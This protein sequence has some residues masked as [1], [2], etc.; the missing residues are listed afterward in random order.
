MLLGINAAAEENGSKT[1]DDVK[2]EAVQA[3]I[4][5][6]EDLLW[7]EDISRL[8]FCE[9]VYNTVNGVKE[10]PVAKLAR[11]PF[12]D[13]NNHKI[14][15]LAFSNIVSG[16][17]E[18]VFAPNDKI[19]R[20]EAAVILCRAAKYAGLEMPTAK[21]DMSYSDNSEISEWAVSG[22]YSL[23]VLEIMSDTADKTF[24]PKA[25][26]TVGESVNSLVKLYK[27]IKK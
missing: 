9:L 26:Y 1:W 17:E 14:N 12:D 27:L 6:N 19:T 20:E 21:V 24:S 25:N 7:N 13:V 8:Q 4:I 2:K 5:E 15:T 11:N 16:K 3:G 23:K 18:N 22:V 10:L